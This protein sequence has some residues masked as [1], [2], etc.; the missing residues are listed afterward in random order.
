MRRTRYATIAGTLALVMGGGAVAQGTPVQKAFEQL[1]VGK[2]RQMVEHYPQGLTSSSELQQPT[3]QVLAA[4]ATRFTMH[5]KLGVLNPGENLDLLAGEASGS[6]GPGAVVINNQATSAN[7]GA[8]R[9]TIFTEQGSL[10]G[11]Y[12]ISG[13]NG[14]KGVNGYTIV[15]GKGRITSGTEA[16]KGVT[17]S[18]TFAGKSPAGIQYFIITF[19]GSYSA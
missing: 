2:Q 7:A 16:L 15:H 13:R 1:G 17:G 4:T 6:L 10:S 19:K 18:L 14:G 8:G 11:K 3:H 5:T 9:F 12:T